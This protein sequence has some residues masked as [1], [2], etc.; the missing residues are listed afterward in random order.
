MIVYR[1]NVPMCVHYWAPFS[2]A[3]P[4]SSRRVS[5]SKQSAFPVLQLLQHYLKVSYSA[6]DIIVPSLRND[7][8][9]SS[10]YGNGW[11]HINHLMQRERDSAWNYKILYL[12][13]VVLKH[14][15][16]SQLPE[17][18]K[19]KVVTGSNADDDIVISVGGTLIL[20]DLCV[21]KTENQCFK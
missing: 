10:A 20:D 1:A 3:I 7:G 9:V 19:T 11:I 18:F 6:G 15:C 21:A 4:F 14:G 8:A 16:T 5:I 2:Y 12:K 17:V 13:V